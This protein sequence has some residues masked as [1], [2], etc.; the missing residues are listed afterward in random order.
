METPADGAIEENTLRWC[1]QKG[2]K[3]FDRNVEVLIDGL[4]AEL[5]L[6]QFVIGVIGDFA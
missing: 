2:V 1:T 6:K 3:D 4:I 5:Y